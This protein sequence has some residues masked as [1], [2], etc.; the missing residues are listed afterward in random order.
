MKLR[1]QSRIKEEINKV[2]EILKNN[3]FETK[4]SISQIKTQ[5]KVWPTEWSKLKIENKKQKTK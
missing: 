1:R 3:Q 4:R 2:I 5:S